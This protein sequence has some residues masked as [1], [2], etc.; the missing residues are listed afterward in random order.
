MQSDYH[1]IRLKKL[2]EPELI[3]LKKLKPLLTRTPKPPP[4]LFSPT[5]FFSL[6]KGKT[7]SKKDIEMIQ[8][9]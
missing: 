7:I 5:L 4:T 1:K 8:D 2:A 9:F 6:S 3:I